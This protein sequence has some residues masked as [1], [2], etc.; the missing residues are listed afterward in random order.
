ML[1]F[2]NP[3]NTL[4]KSIQIVD[5]VSTRIGAGFTQHCKHQDLI[6]SLVSFSFYTQ[7]LRKKAFVF[8][9]F[10]LYRVNS[11]DRNQLTTAFV[12]L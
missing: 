4:F 7:K 5:Q 10:W 1:Y 6:T 11:I 12:G 9:F 3:E 8:I 2:H